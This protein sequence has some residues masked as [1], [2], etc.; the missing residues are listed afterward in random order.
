V[1][2]HFISEQGNETMTD[3]EA[4]VMKGNDPDHATR[5][6]FEAIKHKK[7]PS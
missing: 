7:Y 2:Y 5:D 6:L 1:K 4:T 3:H